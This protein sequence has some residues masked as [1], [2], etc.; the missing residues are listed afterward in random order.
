M[1]LPRREPRTPAAGVL[2]IQLTPHGEL[3]PG[4]LL[5]VSQHGFC[6]AHQHAGFFAGQLVRVLHAWG[7]VTARVVWVGTREGERAAGFRTD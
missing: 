2:P 4:R 7:E 5:D 6:M 3:V 1:P